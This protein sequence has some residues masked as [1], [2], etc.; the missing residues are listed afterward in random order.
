MADIFCGIG[1]GSCVLARDHVNCEV[2]AYDGSEEALTYARGHYAHPRV[3]YREINWPHDR[4]PFQTFEGVVSLESIEHVDEPLKLFTHL[5][6]SVTVGG[7]FVFSTPNGDKLLKTEETFP[8][9]T[10]HWPAEL[11]LELG[12]AV[13]EDQQHGEH[14][15]L[16]L[17]AWGGQDV[18]ALAPSGRVMRELLPENMEIEPNYRGQFIIIAARRVA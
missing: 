14:V 16:E 4:P 5:A 12:D 15:Q 2:Y 11:A 7:V 10:V 18:Y 6:Q 9:H 8:H 13:I 3:S 17:I 1:Y